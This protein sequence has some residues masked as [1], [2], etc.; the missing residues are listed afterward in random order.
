[1]R[2]DDRD[3]A[4][5]KLFVLHKL[6]VPY[7]DDLFRALHAHP[8]VRLQVY[9]LWRGSDRRPWKVTLGTGY[10]NYYLR[11]RLGVDWRAVRDAVRER[12]ALFVVGDWAHL[13]SLAIV[14]A[15]KLLGAPVA[16]WVDTPQEHLARPPLKRMLR[17]AFLRSWVP[18]V[19]AILASGRPARR[20][21]REHFDV[22][23]ERIVDYQFVVDLDWP[24]RVRAD[25][26][27]RERAARWRERVGCAED[28][29]VFLVSGTIDLATKGQDV[30]VRAFARAASRSR[31]R[32]GLLMA[33]AAPRHLAHEERALQRLV[34]EL[35]VGDRVAMLGWLEPEEMA[36]AYLACDVL[37]HP[38]RRDAFPLAVIEAMAW[39]RPVVGTS[40]AGS[41]EER[42]RHGRNGFVVPPDDV[43]A[44]AEAMVEVA[45]AETLRRLSSEAR[46]TA[47]QWPMER[48]VGIFVAL[49][50]RLVGGAGEPV[51]EAAH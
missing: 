33:G 32:I 31:T 26:A 13:P 39:G 47:E 5:R 7:H 28:G 24:D 45:R 35:G 21:L 51:E 14:L 10:P 48:A 34:S 20:A 17:K 38:S 3:G 19:D 41:V 11:P 6:P 40:V 4:W 37:L 18:R 16:L 46:R 36:A 43:E 27:A 12:D 29:V 25:A 8:G 9:H 30:A 2:W 50:D 15:R 44:T 42:V 23:D 49:H 22:P 1:M